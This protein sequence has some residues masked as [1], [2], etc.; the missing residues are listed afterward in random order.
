ME[1]EI[2]LGKITLLYTASLN[3]QLDLLPRLF[4]GIR[5][6]RTTAAGPVFLVDLGRSCVPDTW[7]CE[8]TGSRGMLVAMDAMGYDAFHVGPKDPLYTQPAMVQQLRDV[9]LTPLAAGPWQGK[10]TRQ[11]VTVIFMNA[12]NTQMPEPA[13]LVV[14]LRYSSTPQIETAYYRDR[15]TLL[16]DPGR[17]EP[18]FGRLDMVLTDEPPYILI[19]KHLMLPLPHDAIAD[20]TISSVIEFVESE[21]RYAE[22]KRGS[23]DQSE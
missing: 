11:D 5:H 8:A 18:T 16:L 1:G 14:A 4:T 22:R 13:D 9:I 12:V 2:T 21:A 15:R 23:G 7:I 3:G 19:E 10:A 20:P 17:D 6:E